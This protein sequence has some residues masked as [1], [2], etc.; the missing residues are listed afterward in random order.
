M[1]DEQRDKKYE[2]IANQCKFLMNSFDT[3]MIFATKYEADTGNT[4][5]FIDGRGNWCAR[6]GQIVTWV[7]TEDGGSMQHGANRLEDK[8]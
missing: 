6:Y 1:N 3:V 8:E 5:H 2:L 7:K 4:S